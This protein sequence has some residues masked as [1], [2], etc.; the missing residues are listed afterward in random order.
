[1][2]KYSTLLPVRSW[3]PFLQLLEI[4]DNYILLLKLYLIQYTSDPPTLHIIVCCMYSAG[5][6]WSPFHSAAPRVLIPGTAQG[7]RALPPPQ[8]RLCSP[9]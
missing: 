1:M 8:L 9:E 6:G 3:R 7:H 5:V 2:L 4:I